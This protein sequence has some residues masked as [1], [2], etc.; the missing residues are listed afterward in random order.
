M[1]KLVNEE[2]RRRQRYSR[3]HL[4]RDRHHL[5]HTPR[6][7]SFANLTSRPISLCRVLAR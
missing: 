7:R 1:D 2:K 5:R 3:W 6:F 4:W